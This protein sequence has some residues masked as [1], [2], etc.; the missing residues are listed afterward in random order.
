[1]VNKP[2]V[3][4]SALNFLIFQ[5]LKEADI[6]IP[7]PQRDLHLKSG[8]KEQQQIARDLLENTFSGAGKQNDRD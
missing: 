6:E 5:K 8:L 1:H 4:K 3:L 2:W 7:F